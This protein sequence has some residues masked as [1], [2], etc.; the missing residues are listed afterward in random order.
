MPGRGLL[1]L[2]SDWETI[3]ALRRAYPELNLVRRHAGWSARWWGSGVTA[4]VAT[5]KTAAELGTAIQ[6]AWVATGGRR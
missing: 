1:T 4:P 5:G 3:R 6:E 2:R